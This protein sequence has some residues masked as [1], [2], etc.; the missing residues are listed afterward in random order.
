MLR[1]IR[2][3]ESACL[4]PIRLSAC[5]GRPFS[6]AWDACLL[7]CM[8]A[9]LK[10]FVDVLLSQPGLPAWYLQLGLDGSAWKRLSQLAD[11]LQMQG[12]CSK[13]T[14]A[15]KARIRNISGQAAF[16]GH[17]STEDLRRSRKSSCNNISEMF[18]SPQETTSIFLAQTVLVVHTDRDSAAKSRHR[19]TFLTSWVS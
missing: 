3:H 12:A 9:I 2:P 7:A 17:Y 6:H 11:F 10:S 1:R 8:A 15:I 18:V 19:T 13:A 14:V 5:V 16:Y 4:Q